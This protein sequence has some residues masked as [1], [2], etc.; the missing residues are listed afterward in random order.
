MFKSLSV[1][2]ALLVLPCVSSAEDVKTPT[3]NST[4]EAQARCPGVCQAARG[5]VWA[6]NWAQAGP[7][8][9]V[10]GCT[11]ATPTVPNQCNSQQY[12]YDKDNEDMRLKCPVASRG[13]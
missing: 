2:T 13:L 3:I 11:V 6:S 7:G 1:A 9:S 8:R 12:F 5:Q 10:C 4:V